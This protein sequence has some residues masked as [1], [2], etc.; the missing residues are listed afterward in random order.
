MQEIIP[1]S[2]GTIDGE[3]VPTV[4]LRD[5]H[6]ALGVGRDFATWV[7]DRI[8]KYE[9]EE[10]QDFVARQSPNPGIGGRGGDRRSIDYHA[11]LDMAKELAMVENNSTGRKVRRYFIQVEKEM[12]ALKP[13]EPPRRWTPE[14][15]QTPP[16]SRMSKS[17]RNSLVQMVRT[18]RGIF[19]EDAA[20]EVYRATNLPQPRNAWLVER[21]REPDPQIL[22]V[23]QAL[24]GEALL[25]FL[26]TQRMFRRGSKTTVARMLWRALGEPEARAQMAA[27]GF[28]VKPEGDARTV[29]IAKA[30]PKIDGLLACTD[31]A[32]DWM[33]PLLL[34]PGSRRHYGLSFPQPIGFRQAVILPF[35]LLWAHRPMQHK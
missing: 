12:R 6:A 7:R 3:P 2:A 31:W 8:A 9:F 32:G 10:G 5:L 11:T 26:L 19:G 34:L 20:A 17:E 23:G 21:A 33:T 24:D 30:S 1:I 22:E 25:E 14:P 28:L 13:P 4:N 35:S 15:P 18:V 29:A 27:A 16:L